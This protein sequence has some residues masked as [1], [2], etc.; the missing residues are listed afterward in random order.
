MQSIDSPEKS[1]EVIREDADADTA[2]IDSISPTQPRPPPPRPSSP[3]P[4]LDAIANGEE[5]KHRGPTAARRSSTVNIRD[6]LNAM[7][8]EMDKLRM[9]VNAISP[10]RSDGPSGV[11]PVAH[12]FQEVQNHIAFL[13]RSVG[14]SS[15]PREPMPL[16]S[17]SPSQSS[18]PSPTSESHRT[19]VTSAHDRDKSTRP[20]A[21]RRSIRMDEMMPFVST[22]PVLSPSNADTAD[23]SLPGRHHFPSQPVPPP[24]LSPVAATSNSTTT[25]S[26]SVDI[27]HLVSSESKN[28]APM[29]DGQTKQQNQQIRIAKRSSKRSGYWWKCTKN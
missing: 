3:P 12:A 2:A 27:S 24:P 15:S 26:I 22:P 9:R 28:P 6:E 11:N 10:E 5:L 19:S 17:L 25:P 7:R 14:T 4:R 1:V 8:V 20:I 13:E 29:K 23:S 16:P 21:R 18:Q